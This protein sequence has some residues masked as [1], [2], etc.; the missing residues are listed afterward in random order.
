MKPYSRANARCPHASAGDARPGGYHHAVGH[1][2]AHRA[3][4]GPAGGRHR[5]R[6]VLVRRRVPRGR[7]GMGATGEPAVGPTGVVGAGA[8]GWSRSASCS[9]CTG[10]ARSPP[11][12]APRSEPC[13]SSSSSPRSESPRWRR[14]SCRS[15]STR[16]LSAALALARRRLRLDVSAA[17]SKPAAG[18]AWL[19]SLERGGHVRRAGPAQQ[20][21]GRHLR[22]HTRRTDA[23]D[24]RGRADRS[25]RAVTRALPVAHA[26][27]LWLVVLGVVHTGRR[28]RRVPD[29]AVGRR[30][31]HHRACSAISNRPPPYCGR[32][33]CCTRQP[34]AVTLV[35]GAAILVAGLLVVRN[36]QP[37]TWRQSVLLGDDLLPLLVLALGAAMAFGNILA[38]VR[39]P[40]EPTA[41]AS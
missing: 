34:A 1:R 38:I 27:W 28:H 13:C 29:R 23:D 37:E 30:R 20:T 18:L 41:K 40:R 16:A 39:P 25:G 6:P 32:G 7:V 9:Q 17:P 3:Q 4:R 11:T 21:V 12:N 8:P 24:R 5:G 35:G 22:R 26:A 2:P 36:K 33:W 15:T 10:C 31:D 14:G 19:S